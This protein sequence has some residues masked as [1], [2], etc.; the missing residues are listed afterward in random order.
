MCASGGFCASGFKRAFK[1]KDF[2]NTIPGHGGLVDRLDCQVRMHLFQDKP[3]SARAS[4][5]ALLPC[6]VT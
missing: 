5:L 1:L 3:C 6:T 2:G 4:L